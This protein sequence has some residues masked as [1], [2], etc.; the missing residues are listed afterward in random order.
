VLTTLPVDAPRRSRKR[1]AQFALVAVLLAGCSGSSGFV[2][3]S[4]GSQRFVAGDGSGAFLPE[5]K[6]SLAPV[7]TGRSVHGAELDTSAY[8]GKVVVLNV[9]GSWCAPCKHEQ[10]ALER[11]WTA[12]KAL[13]VQF[14]GINVRDSSE[15][16]PQRHV[17]RFGVTYPSFFDPKSQLVARFRG[18]QAIPSTLVLDRKGR[19]A[20]RVYGEVG[21]DDLVALVRRVAAE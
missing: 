16:A 19:L 9:W 7:L 13:G 17:E 8:A 20:A 3:T 4:S 12:T 2:D 1:G 15:V 14:V 6:R 5:A 18:V 11:A 10:P 21:Y